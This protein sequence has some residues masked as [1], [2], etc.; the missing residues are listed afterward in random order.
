MTKEYYQNI[1]N[2]L[3]KTISKMQSEFNDTINTLNATISGLNATIIDLKAQLGMNSTN[4]SKPP[5]SDGLKKHKTKSL[6]KPSGKKPGGQEK[7]VGNGL[8]LNRAPDKTE[9]HTPAAC[10]TC[11][12][13]SNCT[14][15]TV[16]KA[17][18]TVIDIVATPL[19]TE[20]TTVG[21][22]CPQTGKLQ[23]GRF[24]EGVTGSIQYGTE[25][26]ALAISLNTIGAVSI[27][28]IN[29]IL[30]GV[31]G[32]PISTGTI[33]SM[34]N[35]GAI[36]ARLSVNH[37]KELLC[38]AHL[39][40]F[41]E[42]GIRIKGKTMWAHTASTEKLTYI[43]VEENRGKK[44]MESAGVVPFFKGIGVH[45]CWS[46]Y[47][48]YEFTSALCCAHLLR[49]LTAV[50]E[51]Y[52]QNWAG[53][54]IN[55]LLNM[56]DEKQRLLS[57][58]KNSATKKK[59]DKYSKMYDDIISAA[60]QQNPI[61]VPKKGEKSKKSK[62]RTLAERLVKRKAEYMMFFANFDVPF[63]NNQAERDIRMFKVKQKVSGCFRTKEGADDYA[64]IM[65]YVGTARKHGLSGFVSIRN[66]LLG[67]PF[68]VLTE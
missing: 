10:A 23:E 3:T 24:P 66:I 8:K 60:L 28:R 5:S 38:N 59:L 68:L 14:A 42:T 67:K 43:S 36:A 30:S 17:T 52:N 20:H 33:S 54:F 51:V 48:S 16:K 49:E 12:N 31:F 46:A 29:E 53:D 45:D 40:G 50:V 13:S 58:G 21:L 56:K 19:I 62:S 57:K 15:K 6:R 39:T 34:I 63:D 64:T 32:L 41:D 1:I 11:K 9:I 37:I 7:H 44:G 4:S 47:F 26:K 65:S 25:L 55:L 35:E 27:N 18:R 2:E 61:S 22:I